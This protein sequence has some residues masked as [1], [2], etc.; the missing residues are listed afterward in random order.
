MIPRLPTVRGPRWSLLAV[1]AL[2]TAGSV[3]GCG[4]DGGMGPEGLRFGQIGEVQL[5]VVT[6]LYVGRGTLEQNLVWS[7]DGPYRLEEAISYEGEEGDHTVFRVRTNPESLA[8]EY[9]VW[10]AQ[11]HEAA[12]LQLFV[13]ELDPDL[14]PDCSGELR[15]RLTLRIR[16]EARGETIAW[17]RCVSGSLGYVSTR[18]GPGASAS[19]VANAARFLKSSTLGDA[20]V[21]IYDASLPFATVDRGEDSGMTQT[22]PR[23]ITGPEAWEAFWFDHTDG[24]GETP[25]VDFDKDVILVGAVGVRQEAGDSVEIRRV[26]AVADRTIVALVERLPGNFCSPAERSHVPFHIV[27]TPRA[28]LP[29]PVEFPEPT[30]E[31]VP[32]GI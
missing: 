9:A 10:I 4:T 13:D 19:R 7:S 25:P 27:R 21:S 18:A 29:L 14:D 22:V 2:L 11:I 31:T 1:P 15:T 6:P 5:Q 8:R 12:G 16:D 26:L 3:A 24:D 17:T 28:V 23:A 20:F 30:V 32:C